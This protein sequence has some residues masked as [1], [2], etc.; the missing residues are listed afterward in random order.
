MTSTTDNWLECLIKHPIFKV[1]EK[2]CAA[3]QKTDNS[4]GQFILQHHKCT[5]TLRDNDLFVAVGSKIRV[6][7]LTDFKETHAKE[8]DQQLLYSSVPY[9]LLDTPEID[10]NIHAL[11]PNANGRLLSVVGLHALVVVC[12]PRQGFGDVLLGRT[13][14]CRTLA[15]GKKYHQ[16]LQLLK[17]DWHPLSK[18]HTHLVVLDSD[19]VLRIYDVSMDIEE[20]EQSFELST[21]KSSNKE[22]NKHTLASGH[23]VATF[24]L[25]GQSQEQS[26]WEPFTV[27]YALCNGDMYSICPVIPFESLVHQ[28]Q[29]KNLL[30]LAEFK[31][32]ESDQSLYREQN[33]WLKNLFNSIKISEMSSDYQSVSHASKS[34][35]KR[36][37]PFLINRSQELPSGVQV[38]DLLH[39]ASESVHLLALAFSNG[40]IHNY[41]LTTAVMAQ[42]E[43]TA[44]SSDVLSQKESSLTALL[45]ESID[46]QNQHGPASHSVRLVTHSLDKTIFYAYHAGGVH[47]IETQGW[48]DRLK[49]SMERKEM[50]GWLEEKKTSDVRF[51]INTAPLYEAYSPVVGVCWMNNSYL[52][53]R[54]VAITLDSHLVC[55]D[56][57]VPEP[58][59]P[60]PKHTFKDQL[61]HI[62]IDRQVTYESLLPLP[63]YEQ[64]QRPDYL[65]THTQIVVPNQ[66]EDSQ[67]LMINEDSLALFKRFANKIKQDSDA[68]HRVAVKSKERLGLQQKEFENQIKCLVKMYHVYQSVHSA[69]AKKAQEDSIKA[70]Q[71]RHAQLVLR[72]EKQLGD[73]CNRRDEKLEKEWTEKLNKI[74]DQIHGSS[75]YASKVQ[76][77]KQ[78]LDKLRLQSNKERRFNPIHMSETQLKAIRANVDGL[79]ESVP[80]IV[81]KIKNLE[82]LV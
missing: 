30:S 9:K 69:E 17:V 3:P 75:G 72:V 42:W 5:M 20:P 4:V 52:C 68:L 63:L 56:L 78:Q 10:F 41:I 7:N 22:E 82:A 40:K 31:E 23:N 67:H 57:H 49:E 58:S 33:A 35:V 77:L 15:V 29:L 43:S 1:D 19:S 13:V 18:T 39:I 73:I 79:S 12:L 36:Q 64:P 59:Q 26:Y 11:K 48:V 32:T 62:A 25:G 55:M 71:D 45:Y 53:H 66:L 80:K 51:L 74:S 16:K 14:D 44:K 81:Q 38:T 27:Y 8:N 47:A 70:I 65:P 76:Q 34:G 37:G 54:L 60:T 6:L 2:Q 61:K 46:V 21:T 28:K 24:T 50:K